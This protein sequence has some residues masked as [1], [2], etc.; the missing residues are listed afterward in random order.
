MNFIVLGTSDFTLACANAVLDTKNRIAALI[1]MPSSAR[2]LNSADISQFASKFAIPY[3]EVE[4]I[5]AD[6]TRDI[7]CGYSP[8]YILSSWPKVINK[9]ILK[10]PKKFVIGTHPTELPFN[11]GRHPLHWI[12]ILGIKQTKLSFFR[13]D[14]GIDSG[15][16][17]E[18]VRVCVD[19]GDS[20]HELTKKINAAAYTG[21]K[22]LCARLS[23]YQSYDGI[24]QNKALANYWRK[25]TP[26]DVTLD[27]RM[28]S[29]MIV[30]I[31]KSFSLPY[32]CANLIFKKHIIK[33]VKVKLLPGFFLPEKLQRIEPGRI[34]SVKKRKI[35]VK[36]ADE[37]V[38]LE[39]Q[40]DLPEELASS[41]YIHPPMFYFGGFGDIFTA[42]LKAL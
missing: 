3:H 7:L 40:K 27:L 5:N 4:D 1:S 39:S 19:P 6:S 17:L 18:Q 29:A 21:M 41:K 23:K 9:K 33:I 32:P 22:S 25:R 11:R 36:T 30:R 35:C 31:V 12:I 38:E 26:A 20:I 13:M 42:K 16:I 14:E 2:P 37:V 28:T 8:D 34:I 15:K 24:K 10:V